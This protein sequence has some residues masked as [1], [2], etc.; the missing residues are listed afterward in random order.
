[1]SATLRASSEQPMT[2]CIYTIKT[3]VVFWACVAL[4][5]LLIP[6]LINKPENQLRK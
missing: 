1:M 6:Y 3:Y 4:A 5:V 2:F